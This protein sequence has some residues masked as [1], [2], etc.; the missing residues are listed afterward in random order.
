MLDFLV[1]RVFNWH[2]LCLVPAS[3]DD[4]V[5]IIDVLGLVA[6]SGGL[7]QSNSFFFSLFDIVVQT[8]GV[9]SE[10][11]ERIEIAVFVAEVE[12]LEIG[13]AVLS[14]ILY[15]VVE[16]SNL[17]AIQDFYTAYAPDRKLIEIKAPVLITEKTVALA[18][19]AAF[20]AL[21]RA[22]ATGFAVCD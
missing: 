9:S 2:V 8:L 11:G 3:P 22:L 10:T 13:V 19:A 7:D 21:R 18:Y 17:L 4:Q 6:G 5:S 15:L 20:C 1:V 14:R 12:L 16:H